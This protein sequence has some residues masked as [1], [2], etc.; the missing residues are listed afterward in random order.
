MLALRATT[1]WWWEERPPARMINQV[2]K[3][4]LFGS[5]L[6]MASKAPL[7]SAPT[8]TSRLTERT[9]Q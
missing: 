5:N 3:A 4:D 6:P 8:N 1:I 9:A 7:C 2:R